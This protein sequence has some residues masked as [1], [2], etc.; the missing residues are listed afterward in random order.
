MHPTADL[1]DEAQDRG[2]GRRPLA[3]LTLLP[4]QHRLL[5]LERKHD[6]RDRAA[7]IE[8]AARQQRERLARSGRIARVSAAPAG[9]R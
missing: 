8:L 1:V 7:V 4:F 6:H 2:A 9:V 5:H 3:G